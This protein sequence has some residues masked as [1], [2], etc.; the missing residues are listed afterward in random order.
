MIVEDSNVNGHPI[1]PQF[2]PGPYEA[3][4][5]NEQEFPDDYLHDKKR[6]EKF[7]FCS[8]WILDS[9]LIWERCDPAPWGA[10]VQRRLSSASFQSFGSETL[11]VCAAVTRLSRWSAA[12][13]TLPPALV[14]CA[15]ISRARAT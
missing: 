15:A 2:G 11:F 1:L 14:I 8:Q 10:V 3:I 12:T 7:D 5:A 13:A 6:E 9:S 4:E